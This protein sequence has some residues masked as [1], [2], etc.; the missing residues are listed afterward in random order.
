MVI[1]PDLI[2]ENFKTD[3]FIEQINPITKHSSVGTKHVF[4]YELT[5]IH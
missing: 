1:K 2:W 3:M 5:K 4:N